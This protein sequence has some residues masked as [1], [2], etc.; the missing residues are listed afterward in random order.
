MD[1][2]VFQE[3]DKIK[4]VFEDGVIFRK[5]TFHY[6][7]GLLEAKKIFP[8]R[9]EAGHALK[10]E[11]KKFYEEENGEIKYGDWKWTRNT[12]KKDELEDPYLVVKKR[13]PYVTKYTKIKTIKGSNSYKCLNTPISYVKLS[14]L[15]HK[16]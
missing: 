10:E 2:I 7:I 3:N 1:I 9:R 15:F 13:T 5:K 6:I 14:P 8:G 12:F 11:F 16:G 4:S